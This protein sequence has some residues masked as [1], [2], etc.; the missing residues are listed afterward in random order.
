MAPKVRVS[1]TCIAYS[2][3]RSAL[4]RHIEDINTVQDTYMSV[5][6]GNV[7]IR[8]FSTR[9]DGGVLSIISNTRP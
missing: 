8:N 3:C 7:I 6:K 4:A 9:T 5:F 2:V 1:I